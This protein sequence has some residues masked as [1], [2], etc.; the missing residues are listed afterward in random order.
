[1]VA[2]E[3]AVRLVPEFAVDD[4]FLLAGIVVPPVAH[5]AELD[6][7]AH[8]TSGEPLWALES[9]TWCMNWAAAVLGSGG[10]D[11]YYK[12]DGFPFPYMDPAAL[13]TPRDERTLRD[14]QRNA[15]LYLYSHV[16]VCYGHRFA[17][18][19]PDQSFTRK[20]R[21]SIVTPMPYGTFSDAPFEI[22]L[23]HE[24]GHLCGMPDLYD[25]VPNEGCDVLHDLWPNDN[26][27]MGCMKDFTYWPWLTNYE[28]EDIEVPWGGISPE[29]IYNRW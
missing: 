21:V 2:V 8:P 15:N 23:A 13:V 19:W 9:T 26:R 6:V 11:V 28:I 24:T 14:A 4:S 3:D 5:L 7:M 22:V 10:I 18:L 17:L 20:S 12:I 25:G 29:L 16:L 27:L 1:M